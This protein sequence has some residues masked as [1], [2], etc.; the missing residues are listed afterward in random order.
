MHKKNFN[1]LIASVFGS[2][3]TTTV[4]ADHTTFGIQQDAAGSITTMSAVTLP[5][6]ATTAGLESQFI[7][8]NEISDADLERYADEGEQVHSAATIGSL[9]LN[10][11]RGLTDNLTVGLNLPY[12][13]KTNIREG[14]HHHAEDAHDEHEEAVDEEHEEHEESTADAI[15][16]LGDSSGLGDI[17]VYGQYRFIGSSDSELHVSTLF[18]VKAP[19]G[20]TNNVST[21]GQLLET[22]HQPGSG[23]WDPLMGLTVTRQWRAITVDSNIQYS[24]AG[25]GS[26]STNLGDVVNYNVALSYRSATSPDHDRGSSHHTGVDSHSYWDVAL[27]VNG[28]WRDYVNVAGQRNANSGGN[29]VYLA[30][31]ARYNSGNGWA[32]Y[33]SVG[34][35]IVE[36]LNGIQSDPKLRVFAGVSVGLEIFD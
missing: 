34:V 15:E 28:E 32:A 3:L 36:N 29:L 35:P 18:G 9:S 12:M 1:H 4:F 7:S 27:E 26:Q 8:N 5:R 25:D 17:T 33:V 30:P 20:K 14:A 16:N 2:L 10:T 23:S 31:S 6:S 19:T 13:E 21:D 24:F 11:S 22:E